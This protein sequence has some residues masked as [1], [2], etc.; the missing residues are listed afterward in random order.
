IV[1][2]QLVVASFSPWVGERIQVWGCRPLLLAAFAALPLRG[3]FFATVTNPYLLVAVQLL[4]GVAGVVL[5]GAVPLVI[6]DLTRGTGHFNLGQGVVG[7]A[8]GIGASVS[9]TYAGYLSDHFGS[10]TAFFG[11][12]AVALLGLLTVLTA[13]PET[14]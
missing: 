13:M 5:A 9:T 3:V 11:L 8:M 7:T 1:G 6:A 12:T 2:P 14:R 4:D 10:P